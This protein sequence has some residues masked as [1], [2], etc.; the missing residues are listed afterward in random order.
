MA[1]DSNKSSAPDADIAKLRELRHALLALHKALLDDEQLR[2]EREHGRLESGGKLLQLL[3][4]DPSFAW[5]RVLS[6]LIV[7]IDER[8]DAKEPLTLAEV[9]QIR[10]EVRTAIAPSD[11]GD[12]FQ[13]NYARALQSSPQVVMLQGRVAQFLAR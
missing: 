8:L 3:V 11:L 10:D 5:L 1:A 7:Q 13:R 9:K 4:S 2:Y 6:A 12:E